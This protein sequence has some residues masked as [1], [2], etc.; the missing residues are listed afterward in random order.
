VLNWLYVGPLFYYNRTKEYFKDDNYQYI[1]SSFYG[2]GVNIGFLLDFGFLVIPCFDFGCTLE[3][4]KYTLMARSGLDK[5]E[6]RN[7]DGFGFPLS[8]IAKI[9]IAQNVQVNLRSTLLLRL[10]SSRYNDFI[11]SVGF[12]GNILNGR[13]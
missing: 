3:F 13:K 10:T 7:F 4:T 8:F 9:P 2:P 5:S 6:E 1:V 11:F 12:T